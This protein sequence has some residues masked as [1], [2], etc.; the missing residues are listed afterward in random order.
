MIRRGATSAPSTSVDYGTCSRA[1]RWSGCVSWGRIATGRTSFRRLSVTGPAIPGARTLRRNAARMRCQIRPARPTWVVAAHCHE[2]RTLDQQ[3][4]AVLAD[5][6]PYV[7][8]RP[9][10]EEACGIETTKARNLRC[11]PCLDREPGLRDVRTERGPPDA[12]RPPGRADPCRTVPA[13]RAPEPCE[14]T[15]P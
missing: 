15:R 1:W 10:C 7:D 9:V 3:C 8:S 2:V 4:A 13:S 11:G 14:S 12:S 6:A 5:S